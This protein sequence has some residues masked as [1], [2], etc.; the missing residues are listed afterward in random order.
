MCR[1]SARESAG[2]PENRPDA[3]APR[4][5]VSCAPSGLNEFDAAFTVC[6]VGAHR[7]TA[8][9]LESVGEALRWASWRERRAGRR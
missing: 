8:A 4:R 3:N 1:A 9:K 2:A 7:R 5:F 6:G